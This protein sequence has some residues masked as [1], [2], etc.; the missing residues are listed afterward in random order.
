M[1]HA[2]SSRSD[3]TTLTRPYKT[4]ASPN[5][6]KHRDTMSPPY[7]YYP[8]ALSSLLLFPRPLLGTD[9]FSITA[10]YD[11]PPLSPSSSVSVQATGAGHDSPITMSRPA[12]THI[13]RKSSRIE[14]WLSEQHRIVHTSRGDLTPVATK[15]LPYLVYPQPSA[16]SFVRQASEDRESV[17]SYVVV[18]DRAPSPSRSSRNASV[19]STPSRDSD[20]R[21]R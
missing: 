15:S 20:H 18:S 4:D 11:E 9:G 14:A 5:P 6:R 13:R 10:T 1:I 16:A 8:G 17:D 21:P 3:T 7:L 12:V 19:V 2:L